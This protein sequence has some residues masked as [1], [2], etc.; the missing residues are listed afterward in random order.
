[1][2]ARGNWRAI[3]IGA[4]FSIAAAAASMGWL[5]YHEGGGDISSGATILIEQIAQT[6]EVHRGMDDESP[7]FSW[8]R[9]DLFAVI[10]KWTGSDPGD[11]P[12]VLVMFL[13]LGLPMW[14]LWKRHRHEVDDGI[15]GA[16]GGLM[17]TALLV[18]L[19]HQ[20]YDALLLVPP[21]VGIVCCSSPQWHQTSIRV[22][23]ILALLLACP[24]LNYLS[25]R[26]FLLRLDLSE[27]ITKL[28]TSA[29]GVSLALALM[30]LCWVM[31]SRLRST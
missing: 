19:Y 31:V 8:T 3:L 10:A 26:M 7:V 23:W 4:A 14:I 12:H 15:T 16:T 28:L 29:N 30:V 27:T 18:S 24:L 17:M 1:M 9:L 25:T 22:R 2:I 20:S 13:I 6:Q 11:L 5:A 21:I